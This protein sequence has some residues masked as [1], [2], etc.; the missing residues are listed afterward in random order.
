M[1]RQEDDYSEVLKAL[2]DPAH[3]AK[4]YRGVEEARRF[5][6]A[7]RQWFSYWWRDRAENPLEVVV[8][9]FSFPP[10]RDETVC[11]RV[12]SCQDGE[13]SVSSGE[14]SGRE[15]LWILRERLTRESAARLNTPLVAI[16]EIH[17]IAHTEALAFMVAPFF[18]WLDYVGATQGRDSILPDTRTQQ[19]QRASRRRRIWQLSVLSSLASLEVFL[20]IW[21]HRCGDFLRRPASRS[22]YG[23]RGTNYH[24]IPWVET[25]LLE[26]VVTA[27]MKKRL[28]EIETEFLPFFATLERPTPEDLQNLGRTRLL[29]HAALAAEESLGIPQGSEQSYREET[30]NALLRESKGWR[31]RFRGT[32][33]LVPDSDRTASGHLGFRYL[34]V[35]LSKPGVSRPAVALHRFATPPPDLVTAW[36]NLALYSRLDRDERE[37]SHSILID[38]LLDG[39]E[40]SAGADLAKYRSE[41][42]DVEERLGI[43]EQPGGSGQSELEEERD[44]LKDAIMRKWLQSNPAKSARTSVRKAIERAIAKLPPELATLREH[45][46]TNV[47]RRNTCCYRPSQSVGW[48]VV[49]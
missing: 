20:D 1:A 32:E 47:E 49:F 10:R 23:T 31:V 43:L 6:E 34:A 27:N 7:V 45:L 24:R 21:Q 15:E 9:D 48:D 11:V 42:S 30:G 17:H 5:S 33:C 28:D 12:L 36:P 41:L 29:Q 8:D 22:K 38:H 4:L 16:A 14:E 40:A 19:D 2:A 26:D 44:L 35:L 13:K 25:A 18:L 39:M 3:R 37:E 46:L